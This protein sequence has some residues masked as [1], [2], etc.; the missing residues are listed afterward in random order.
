MLAEFLGL[1]HA[2][3]VVKVDVD[4][5]NKRILAWMEQDEGFKEVVN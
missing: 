5:T 4:I 2:T 1:P 3:L